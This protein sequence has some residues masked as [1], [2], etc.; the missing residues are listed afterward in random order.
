MPAP[1]NTSKLIRFYT[2]HASDQTLLADIQTFQQE[3]SLSASETFKE[4]LM[5]GLGT[6]NPENSVTGS[7]ETPDSVPDPNVVRVPYD[8]SNTEDMEMLLLQQTYADDHG[9]SLADTVKYLADIGAQ[10]Q[11]PDPE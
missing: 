4:L 8:I 1:A 5:R 3:N 7:S 9:Y 10:T 2:D 11:V 6:E